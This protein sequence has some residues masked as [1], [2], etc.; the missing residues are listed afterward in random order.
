MYKE[1]NQTLKNFIMELSQTSWKT[2]T[3]SEEA[4]IA[5]EIVFVV[6]QL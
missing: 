1:I 5:N 2:N 6:S 4:L 3:S